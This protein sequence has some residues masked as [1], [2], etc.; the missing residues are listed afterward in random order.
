MRAVVNEGS[1]RRA[2]L[3]GVA[4]AGKTGSAQVV[5]RSRLEKT[6][7]AYEL[8]PHGW[9]VCFAPAEAPRIAM[10]VLVEHGRSG[11]ESAVP[12]AREILAEYFGLG[13]AMPA[14][15]RT[16]PPPAQAAG[17]L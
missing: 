1:G 13:T 4:V 11:A 6:P 16:V 9:F 3:V 14:V 2:R 17:G 8:L 12:V 15:G 7:N 5:A 10:A